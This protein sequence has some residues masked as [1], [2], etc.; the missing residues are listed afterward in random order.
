MITDTLKCKFL[1]YDV[2]NNN[3]KT[4]YTTVTEKL[5]EEDYLLW[6]DETANLLKSG[7]FSQ[8]DIV[9]LIEEIEFLGSEQRRKVK[10]YL[11]Q[12][13]K[14]LLFYQYWSLPDCKH[15]WSGE[16]DNFRVELRELLQS[17]TLYNYFV[18][19]KDEVYCDALR[20]AKK[21]SELTCFPQTCPYT[22][23][24]IL[25]IDFYPQSL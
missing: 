11:R 4:M 15:H 9:H 8:L 23:E 25:N 7:D 22:I 5:Y 13:L 18:E 6:L 12:L 24:E 20:Q 16:I 17:K 3:E 21:K 19:V 1:F 10:S 2:S 14:H